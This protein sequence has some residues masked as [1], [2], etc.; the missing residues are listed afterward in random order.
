MDVFLIPTAP[1][2]ALRALLRGAGRRRRGG[3]R[4]RPASFDR[5]KRRFADMLH[6]AEEWR[7]RRHEREPGPLAFIDAGAPQGHGLRRRAHRRTAA[8]VA[9]AQ[10]RRGLRAASRR[11]WPAAT[12]NAVIRATLKKDADHHLRWMLIDLAA[13]AR[14]G[15]AR[16]SFP[17]PT[18]P[19]STSR[20]RW[21]AISSRGAARSGALGASNVDV[22]AE[23]GI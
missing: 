7:H 19:A 23:R 2:A 5:M 11:I 6:E 8:A 12:P 10:G 13:A 4:G 20:S 1:G 14:L 21:S 3:G 15:A 16:R 18:S 22:Q 9:H 17:G